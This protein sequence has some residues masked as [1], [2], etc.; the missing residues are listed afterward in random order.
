[1]ML[2]WQLKMQEQAKASALKLISAALVMAVIV[3]DL[4]GFMSDS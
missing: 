1:M 3:K 2:F 4:R